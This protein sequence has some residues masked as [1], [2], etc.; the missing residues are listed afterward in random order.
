MP[1][2]YS[3]PHTQTLIFPTNR[4]LIIPPLH[5]THSAN[6]LSFFHTSV[7]SLENIDKLKIPKN[8][9]PPPYLPKSPVI[10]RQHPDNKHFTLLIQPQHYF[11]IPFIPK[12]TNTHTISHLTNLSPYLPSQPLHPPYTLQNPNQS[13]LYISQHTIPP[14]ILLTLSANPSLQQI[15]NIPFSSIS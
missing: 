6:S 15:L 5:H 4:L 12:N 13:H 2:L 10:P 3:P 1:T 11:L 9:N 8:H 7:H 14:L